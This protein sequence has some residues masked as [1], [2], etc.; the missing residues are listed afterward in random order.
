MRKFLLLTVIAAVVQ[1]SNAQAPVIQPVRLGNA[2]IEQ[3]MREERPIVSLPQGANSHSTR[4][5][6]N[7]RHQGTNTEKSLLNG[8]PLNSQRVGSAGNLL[9]ITEGNCNQLYGYSSLNLVSFIHRTDPT[10]SPTGNIAQ[11]SFDFSKDNGNT[12]L[13]NVGPFTNQASPPIDNNGSDPHGRF[14]Q[15]TIFNTNGNS[16]PDSAY[17]V[18]SGT[19]HD[20]APAAT[21]GSWV[22]QMRGR[23]QFT[24]D[25]STFNIHVDTI[26]NGTT[27]IATGLCPGAPGVFWAVNL[28][29]S[30]TFATTSNDITS[31]IIVEKGVWN[32]TTHDIDW[33]AHEIV[34]QFDSFTANSVNI[35]AAQSFDIAFDPTGQYGWIS[36]LGDVSTAPVDSVN[37]PIFWKTIDGGNTWT[38][39]ISVLLDSV[40]GVVAALNG[41]TIYPPA[42]G[43]PT[44]AVT[45]GIPTTSFEAKLTVDYLGNPHLFTTVGNGNGYSIESGAGYTAYDITLNPAN[46]CTQ[47]WHGWAAI[48]VDSIQTLRGNTTQDATPLTEDNR[49]L[50]SRSADGTKLFFFWSASDVTLTQADNNEFPNLFVR[51]F[52]I[53]HSTSTPSINLTQ[54]DPLWGGPTTLDPTGGNV[55]GGTLQG[56]FYPTVSPIAIPNGSTG[57]TIPLILT[58]IDYT[59]NT[60]QS[61]NPAQFWYI[62]NINFSEFDFTN[63]VSATLTPIGSDTVIIV[64]HSAYS[65]SGATIT[66]GDTACTHSGLLHVVTNS[67]GLNVNVPG[68]YF[69]NYAA[70]DA[71]GNIYAT[72]NRVVIVV[73]PPV[74]KFVDIVLSGLNVQFTDSSLYGPTSWYWTFGDGGNDFTQNPL[75]T[76]SHPGTYEV[77][78]KDSNAYGSSAVYCDSV[79]VISVGINEVDFASHISMFPN[80]TNGLVSITLGGVISDF[81]VSVYNVLGGE[82]MAAS[83]YKTG[84]T[85]VQLSVGSFADGVYLVK[86]QSNQ[87]SAVKRLVVSHK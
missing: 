45:S 38:G 10:V 11:Y 81:T 64:I 28:D 78:L 85:N 7:T 46:S 63:G 56:A 12:W 25:S 60:G 16:N 24:G 36:C 71:G 42:S 73:S 51:G 27:D 4:S 30:G 75:H 48:F 5:T 26:N 19:W 87:G 82:V 53:V 22:G 80:P 74:A 65:D 59:T 1:I 40:P 50:V 31:G 83:E 23:G 77:C 70:E 44:G 55:N 18:Y 67:S 76:Y 14:P 86:I 68:T 49:P 3:S 6:T 39:P 62:N 69:I 47:T 20:A 29:W 32:S 58:Q 33:T 35:S 13:N 2:W 54:G 84:T 41:V 43:Q 9:T 52:D 17:L 34:Q 21:S 66:Y 37:R 8:T 57:F 15:A 79:H 61:A 72:G